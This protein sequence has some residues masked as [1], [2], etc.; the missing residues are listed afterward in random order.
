MAY[1]TCLDKMIISLAR[2]PCWKNFYQ[3]RVSFRVLNEKHEK[4]RKIAA[5][6]AALFSAA[7]EICFWFLFVHHPG[8]EWQTQELYGLG[9]LLIVAVTGVEAFWLYRLYAVFADPCSRMVLALAAIPLSV[10]G[11]FIHCVFL[12]GSAWGM[13]AHEICYI[14]AAVA[15]GFLILANLLDLWAT[16]WQYDAL[17]Y[18]PG[19]DD[20]DRENSS[21]R[22]SG[23]QYQTLFPSWGG[24]NG[25]SCVMLCGALVCTIS[26]DAWHSGAVKVLEWCVLVLVL[27]FLAVLF[28]FL[29]CSID[30]PLKYEELRNPG[31]LW[32]RLVYGGSFPLSLSV[33]VVGF[34]CWGLWLALKTDLGL[35]WVILPMALA[36]LLVPLLNVVSES[37]HNRVYRAKLFWSGFCMAVYSLLLTMLGEL[38]VDQRL[39]THL[40]VCLIMIP[41]E[42]AALV[43]F[44]LL[45]F[46]EY[47]SCR[48][49]DLKWV[50]DS[51]PY[52][53]AGVVFCVVIVVLFYDEYSK[54]VGRLPDL[55]A[56]I[57]QYV[58]EPSSARDVSQG[59]LIQTLLQLNYDEN[60]D[61]ADLSSISTVVEIMMSTSDVGVTA[62]RNF[63]SAMSTFITFTY[64][65]MVWNARETVK[66]TKL[67]WERMK[68]IP[69]RFKVWTRTLKQKNQKKRTT[70]GKDEV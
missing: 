25:P 58:L 68:T 18:N 69:W 57:S 42:V 28:C 60:S 40:D 54:L 59:Q 5:L 41:L 9:G 39:Y 32:R 30:V 24:R 44:V 3:Q 20:A 55:A 4:R 45:C 21:P 12:G 29:L 6:V 27:W 33:G 62:L 37:G 11:F 34:G 7:Q 23:M 26:L 63:L 1:H 51:F 13:S 10:F 67:W 35:R 61:S 48:H 14:C 64:I 47:D 66:P 56:L 15:V 70:K 49:Q 53:L 16:R 38:F 8:V 52:Q 43:E 2:K 22:V 46:A 31:S 65:V 19:A 50:A 36:I 17:R